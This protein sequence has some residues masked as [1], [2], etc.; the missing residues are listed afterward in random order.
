M[1]A[2]VLSLGLLLVPARVVASPDDAIATAPSAYAPLRAVTVFLSR[3]QI[4][5][6][7]FAATPPVFA[8]GVPQAGS[9]ATKRHPRRPAIWPVLTPTPARWP[10][11]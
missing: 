4:G 11:E 3:P 8:I 5:E 10:D 9:A 1:R 2:I 7:P 6:D